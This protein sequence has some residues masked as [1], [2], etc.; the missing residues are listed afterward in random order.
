M[1]PHRSEILAALAERGWELREAL[2][3]VDA[4][5]DA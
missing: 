1:E 2:E 3:H 4:F 5:R